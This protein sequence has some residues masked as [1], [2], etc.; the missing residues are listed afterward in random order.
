[1][2]GASCRTGQE[3]PGLPGVVAVVGGLGLGEGAVQ[4]EMTLLLLYSLVKTCP[5]G[6]GLGRLVCAEVPAGLVTW[7][8]WGAGQTDLC[9]LRLG[10]RPTRSAKGWSWRAVQG[11]ELSRCSHGSVG[12]GPPLPYPTA[13][14]DSTCFSRTGLMRQSQPWAGSVPGCRLDAEEGSHAEPA[15]GPCLRAPV[16]AAGRVLTPTPW[17]LLPGCASL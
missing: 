4:G 12:M 16:T 17:L 5:F 9:L 11:V 15:L 13:H 14:G 8:G 6:R 10:P 1:M 2:S 3:A 7:V